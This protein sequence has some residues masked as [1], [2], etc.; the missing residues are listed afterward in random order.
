MA[1][2]VS[3]GGVTFGSPAVVD[4]DGTQWVLSRIQ[5]WHGGVSVRGERQERPGAHGTFA[6]RAWRDGRL[7][8]VEGAVLCP[9]RAVAASAVRVLAAVLADGQFGELEVVDADEGTLSAQVRLGAEPT[10]DWVRGSTT[11]RY[12][13]PLYAPDPLRYGDLVSVSTGFPELVGGLVYPLYEDED[14]NDVGWLDYGPPSTSGVVAL[15]NP[16]TA[17]S[18]PQFEVTGPAPGFEVV[19]VGTGERLVFDGAVPAGSV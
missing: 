4:P 11:V 14:G 17:T 12:Q 6:E 16:G 15:E 18:Y 13:F 5:G 2:T 8:I 7:T 19:R 9:S 10:V 1:T 3:F